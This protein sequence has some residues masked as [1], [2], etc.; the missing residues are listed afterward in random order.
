[1][2]IATWAIG[3]KDSDCCGRWAKKVI[4]TTSSHVPAHRLE[5]VDGIAYAQYWF[6]SNGIATS[7]GQI[8]L[9]VL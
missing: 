8:L 7:T 1:M 2:Q 5:N 9:S 4:Q 6:V 3:L